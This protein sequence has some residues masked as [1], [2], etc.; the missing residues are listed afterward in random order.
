MSLL[1]PTQSLEQQASE[2]MKGV[3]MRPGKGK[4]ASQWT[5]SGGE[6]NRLTQNEIYGRL[7]ARQNA[8]GSGSGPGGGLRSG[9]L[10]PTS[11]IDWLKANGPERYAASGG[12]KQA[13]RNVKFTGDANKMSKVDQAD[14]DKALKD[15]ADKADADKAAADKAAKTP[16]TTAA[17][18]FLDT[19]PWQAPKPKI[20]ATI[21]RPPESPSTASAPAPTA[22]VNGTAPAK[23][24]DAPAP[25]TPPVLAKP[26]STTA[27]KNGWVVG[28]DMIARR[29][30]GTSVI[31]DGQRNWLNKRVDASKN[32]PKA[33]VMAGAQAMDAGA[34][35][36]KAATASGA[37]TPPETTP[38]VLAKPQTANTDT[39]TAN[40]L[41]GPPPTLLDRKRQAIAGFKDFAPTTTEEIAGAESRLL[42][43]VVPTVPGV[44][45]SLQPGYAENAKREEQRKALYP[46]GKAPAPSE[47]SPSPFGF[48]TDTRAPKSPLTAPSNPLDP[49]KVSQN[50]RTRGIAPLGEP[51]LP[52][53]SVL[54]KPTG[55]NNQAIVGNIANKRKKN[56]LSDM[57]KGIV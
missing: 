38:P 10:S 16:A 30:D 14:Y 4:R 50:P 35:V 57:L 51:A 19:P 42:P 18:D 17:P 1:S 31:S 52:T 32:K 25:A 6:F 41:A 45:P 13:E 37:T 24:P 21:A 29:A 28:P 54:Q 7:R 46:N 20:P 26:N 27:E 8:E 11:G 44:A 43:P 47:P 40:P 12:L 22:S 39:D 34:A 49:V 23:A 55:P 33:T 2:A 48:T 5:A 36:T 53:P 56:P 3:L 15:A 9:S